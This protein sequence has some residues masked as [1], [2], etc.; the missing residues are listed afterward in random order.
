MNSV[1][2]KIAEKNR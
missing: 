1:L 2:A